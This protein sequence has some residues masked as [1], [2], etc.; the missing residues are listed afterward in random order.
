MCPKSILIIVMNK[1]IHVLVEIAI[2]VISLYT[3]ELNELDVT[4]VRHHYKVFL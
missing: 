2:R 3:L 1:E 4:E